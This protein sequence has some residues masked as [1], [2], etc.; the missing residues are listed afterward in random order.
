MATT[1]RSGPLVVA[2]GPAERGRQHGGGRRGR[3]PICVS[4]ADPGGW[5]TFGVP[6]DTP[7]IGLELE[8]GR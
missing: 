4:H 1:E 8:L 2:G 5:L 3:V 6:A 7:W